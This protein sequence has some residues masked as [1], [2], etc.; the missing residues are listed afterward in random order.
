[1]SYT[2]TLHCGCLVYVSCH[3]KTQLAHTRIIE[4]RGSACQA[5]LHDVGRQLQLWD[6]LP[7]DGIANGPAAP[8]RIWA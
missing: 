7:D 1:M 3:P 2:L 5:R 8:E 4:R 6:L